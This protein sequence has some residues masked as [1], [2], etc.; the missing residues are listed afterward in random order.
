MDC[1]AGQHTAFDNFRASVCT[2]LE[3]DLW[4][5]LQNSTC[6]VE[7]FIIILGRNVSV[8]CSNYSTVTQNSITVLIENLVSQIPFADATIHFFFLL[9]TIVFRS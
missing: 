6:P 5:V 7:C 2:C 1:F 9:Q 4:V 8:Q 3:M